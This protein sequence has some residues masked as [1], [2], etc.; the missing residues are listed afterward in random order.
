MNKVLVQK[1]WDNNKT[2]SDNAK[3]LNISY[4]SAVSYK[5]RLK[6][7][8]KEEDVIKPLLID[9]PIMGLDKVLASFES[10]RNSI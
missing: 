6:L 4:S 2:I 8:Y 1:L 3:S 7:N 10:K 5:K 9:Y